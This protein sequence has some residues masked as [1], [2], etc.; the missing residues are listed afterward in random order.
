VEHREKSPCQA[1]GSG[2]SGATL[3]RGNVHAITLQNVRQCAAFLS[4]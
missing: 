2:F 1:V 4:L 3:G